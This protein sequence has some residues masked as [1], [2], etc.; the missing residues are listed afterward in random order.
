MTEKFSIFSTIIDESLQAMLQHYSDLIFDT[1][2][3]LCLRNLRITFVASEGRCIE[4]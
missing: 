2:R 4:I 1:V 3:I